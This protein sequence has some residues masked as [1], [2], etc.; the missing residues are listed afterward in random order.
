[1]GPV[2]TLEKSIARIPAQGPGGVSLLA[3]GGSV[4][5]RSSRSA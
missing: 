4:T 3:I 5:A 1:M 2:T